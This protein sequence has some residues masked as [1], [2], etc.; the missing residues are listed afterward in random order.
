M[1]NSK[2]FHDVVCP[3]CGKN[4]RRESDTMDTF[5]CSSWYY[6]RY[7]DPKNTSEFASKEAMKKWLPVDMYM[8]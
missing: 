1:T 5:V 7:S 4:A 2:T 6:L 8:G 3:K